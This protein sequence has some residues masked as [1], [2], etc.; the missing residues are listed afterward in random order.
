M[1]TCWLFIKNIFPILFLGTEIENWFCTLLERLRMIYW[2]SNINTILSE[3]DAISSIRQLL[4]INCLINQTTRIARI[5]INLHRR[6]HFYHK[7]ICVLSQKNYR[8]QQIKLI[9]FCTRSTTDASIKKI[10]SNQTDLN[11]LQ[12]LLKAMF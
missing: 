7:N 10:I 5:S 9:V 1:K 3:Y 2:L 4:R 8:Q 11:C 12:D 6:V